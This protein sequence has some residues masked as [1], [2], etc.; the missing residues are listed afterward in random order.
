MIIQIVQVDVGQ[1]KEELW[2]EAYPYAANNSSP[3]FLRPSMY[4]T[5]KLPTL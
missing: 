1:M 4:S 3:F 5:L 2:N